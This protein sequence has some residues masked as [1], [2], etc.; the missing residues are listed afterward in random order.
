MD[1]NI[2]N[3][4][5]E[6]W[7]NELVARYNPDRYIHDKRV[8]IATAAIVLALPLG[9]ENNFV[10]DVFIRIF[11]FVV[12]AESFNIIAGYAG[13]FSLGHVAFF[14]LGSYTTA[15]LWS[16]GFDPFLSVIASGVVA[17]LIALPIGYISITT[18]GIYFALVTLAFAEILLVLFLNVPGLGRATGLTLQYTGWSVTFFYYLFFVVAV[19]TV[20]AVYHLERSL[21]GLNFKMIREDERLA[22]SFGVHAK[23]NKLVAFLLS[24][25]FPGLVGGVWALYT[26]YIQPE[27]A[28]SI[29]TSVNMQI[30][31]ILGGLGTVVG[32]I[33]GATL[34]ISLEEVTQVAT[35]VKNLLYGALMILIILYMPNGVAGLFERES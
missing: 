13:L 16:S 19:L 17:L 27:S 20:A 23:R 32:P 14:G 34:L 3:R 29:W 7:K 24:A 21:L 15:V 26:A 11:M 6:L 2:R 18:D 31:A 4:A 8:W 33:L 28:F 10:L 25:F 5:K 9:I 22:Q 1:N 12:L 35:E 30:F